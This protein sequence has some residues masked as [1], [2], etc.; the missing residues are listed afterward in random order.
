MRAALVLLAAVSAYAQTGEDARQIIESL[1]TAVRSAG[2]VR[3]EGVSV[4]DT[5]GP[6]PSR[7]ETHFELVTQGP[8][9]MRYRA[10]SGPNRVLRICDGTSRWDYLE[11]PNSYTRATED[12]AICAPP[13]ADWQDLA[14]DVVS[15][16]ITGRSHPEIEGHS[17]ECEVIE[18]SYGTPKPFADATL[19][20]GGLARTLCVDPVRHVILSEQIRYPAAAGP[21]GPSQY[22][23]T[24]A[25]SRVEYNPP[26]DAEVF[27]F[28]PPAGSS[29][30][31][32][33]LPLTGEG[34]SGS[35]AGPGPGS[36]PLLLISKREPEYSPEALKAKLQ[37][38]VLIRLVVDENG[39]PRDMKVLRGL[40]MGLDEKAIEAVSG[41]RFKPGTRAGHRIPTFAQVEV[42]FRIP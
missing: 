7:Q 2:S 13:V 8:L 27:Q 6:A 34:G 14:E 37:G 39:V 31:G 22:S 1:A 29:Q 38:S 36:S 19:A 42:S 23:M 12:E 16:R 32:V 28:H 18:V 15:A 17:Q 9:L 21:I 5:T 26:Q 41:W 35:Y 4:E 25:Y 24:I 30:G 40:G 20:A 10:V 11:A 3:A 33:S